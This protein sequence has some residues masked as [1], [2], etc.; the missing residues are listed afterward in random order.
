ME[1]IRNYYKAET[2]RELI[3]DIKGDTSGVYE[4]ICVKLANI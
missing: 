2:K 3:E 1:F 4:K